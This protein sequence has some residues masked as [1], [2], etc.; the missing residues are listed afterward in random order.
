MTEPGKDRILVVGIGNEF[1]GDDGA[2]IAVLRK[3]K[4]FFPE[5]IIYRESDGEALHLVS[6]WEDFSVVI[7]IDA[8]TSGRPPG[9]IHKY[10]LL[11]ERLPEELR[12]LSG[13]TIGLAEAVAIARHLGLLPDCLLF[14]GIEGGRYDSGVYLTSRIRSSVEDLTSVIRSDL[15]SILE[16]QPSS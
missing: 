6:L 12:P 8:V 1:R 11:H 13:H 4:N 3:I 16:S 5:R 7:L 2:G 9:T 14:Y 15:T 10:D